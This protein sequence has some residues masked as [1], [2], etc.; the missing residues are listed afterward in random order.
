MFITINNRISKISE[1]LTMGEALLISSAPSRQYTTG[2]KSSAGMVLITSD[3]AIFLIDSRYYEKALST[4]KSCEVI[5]AKKTYEQLK[6]ILIKEKIDTL[7]TE[8]SYIS[9]EEYNNLSAKLNPVTISTDNKLNNLLLELRSIKEDEELSFIR[10]SQELTD[11]T[12]QYILNFIKEGKTER[13][14]ALEMEFFM[15]R[16]G[17]EGIAFDFIVVSGKNSSLPHG[18]PTDKPFCKGDFVTMDFGGIFGGYCS[19]MTRTVA[20]GDVTEEQKKVYKTVLKAQKKGLET[21]KAGVSG[22][23]A[24]KAARDIIIKAGY[25]EYF[26]HALGHSVGLEIHES[27]NCSPNCKTILQSGTVM[28]VEPG[29]YIPDKFGVRIEDMVVVTEKGNENLTKSPKELIIL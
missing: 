9:L 1:N 17:A 12:F 22:D 8:T 10:Y 28:T 16:Q 26:G 23:V 2:F 18:V 5:L 6:D 19:D 24:D 3:H 15:R 25:G 20:I 4:V 21:I 11:K 29:I 14:T 7:Y 13:E 27:P